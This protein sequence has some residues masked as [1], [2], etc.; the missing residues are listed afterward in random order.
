M[1]HQPHRILQMDERATFPVTL[2]CSC[3]EPLFRGG[4]GRKDAA[5]HTPDTRFWQKHFQTL[6]AI[7]S[8]EIGRLCEEVQFIIAHETPYWTIQNGNYVLAWYSK[9]DPFFSSFNMNK[10]PQFFQ[11]HCLLVWS[12]LTLLLCILFVLCHYLIHKTEIQLQIFL[13]TTLDYIPVF[14]SNLSLARS[15]L[16]W[17][18][19]LVR[20]SAINAV[21][22]KYKTDCMMNIK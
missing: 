12:S 13:H 8:I 15:Q 2:R 3:A 22:T 6:K 16:R 7:W 18:L 14:G 5:T 1:V 11:T 10:C 4:E 9:V 19:L 20:C 21:H 17:T